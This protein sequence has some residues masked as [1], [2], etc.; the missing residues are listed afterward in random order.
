MRRGTDPA[1][2]AAPFR[3]ESPDGRTVLLRGKI[4]RVD[5]MA[6]PDG[7]E[8][9]FVVDYKTGELPKPQEDVQL[10]VYIAA[11]AQLTGLAAAGG[12]FHGVRAG[13][14]QERYLADFTVARRQA[15]PKTSVFKTQLDEGLSLVSQAVAGIAGGNFDIFADAAARR[16]AARTGG[17]AGTATCRG[18]FKEPA[19]PGR[20]GGGPWLS[21]L[22]PRR[23]PAAAKRQRAHARAAGLHRAH[24][25]EHGR[26]QRGRLRQDVRADAA[27]P[28]PAGPGRPAGCPFARS[29]PSPSP[30]RR[31]WR[32]ASAS[33]PSWPE[34]TD[35]LAAPGGATSPMPASA[36]ST[37]LPPRCCAAG[38]VEAGVDPAFA[39]LADEFRRTQMRQAACQ[40]ALLAALS[41][42]SR[43]GGPTG[44]RL[45]YVRVLDMLATLMDERWRW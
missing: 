20:A 9:L 29:S 15:S 3:L 18:L 26:H 1:S 42:Q 13:R 14:L 19:D 43:G 12:A 10:P 37:A 31:P 24:G 44:R 25:P 8:R 45:G 21:N 40:D 6:W 2:V 35:P 34:R 7:G 27:I 23:R 39:V 36:R 22:P 5:V 17:S 32:C 30:T 4:D 33:R 28:A 41:R 11:A 38:P 16:K